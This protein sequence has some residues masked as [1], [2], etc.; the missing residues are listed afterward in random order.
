LIRTL[1]APDIRLAY[2]VSKNNLIDMPS[3]MMV[4]ESKNKMVESTRQPTRFPKF[5]IKFEDFETNL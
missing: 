2:Y 1:T 5:S 3:E 4:R